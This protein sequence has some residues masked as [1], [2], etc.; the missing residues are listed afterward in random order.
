MPVTPGSSARV[1]A[2]AGISKVAKVTSA[3]LSG[4]IGDRVFEAGILIQLPTNKYVMTDG[5]TA[6]KNLLPIIDQRLTETEKAALSA[7]YATGSYV[8]ANNGVVQ[9]DNTGTIDDASFKFISVETVN[10]NANTHVIKDDYL[11][12]YIDPSTNLVRLSALPSTVRAGVAFVADITAR[13]GLAADAE[14]RLGLVWVLDA[15]DDTTVEKDMAAYIWTDNPDYTGPGDTTHDAKIWRKV[16]EDD[17]MDI[18]IA[19]LT[20]DYG[21][22]QA[23]GAV[24]YDHTIMMTAP[25]LT[26]LAALQDA[27]SGSGSAGA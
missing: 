18:D 6:L 26:E 8:R 20:P 7:A 11:T 23:A 15:S 22:V 21:N 25:S 27:G 16:A 19:A 17:S 14:E 3:E 24:M 4:T 10:G 5:T 9:H 12:K 2:L 1:N 13:D